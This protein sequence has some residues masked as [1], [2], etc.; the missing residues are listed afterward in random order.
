M[1][2]DSRPADVGRVDGALAHAIVVRRRQGRIHR[3]ELLLEL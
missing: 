2:G 3:I 1:G